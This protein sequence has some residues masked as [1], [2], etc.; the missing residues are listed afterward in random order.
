MPNDL[1]TPV[2]EITE[3]SD[4]SHSASGTHQQIS[5]P[6]RTRIS[7][8]EVY[9]AACALIQLSRSAQLFRD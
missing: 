9:E 1:G 2:I 8:D 6:S 7:T 5:A 4:A 3:E